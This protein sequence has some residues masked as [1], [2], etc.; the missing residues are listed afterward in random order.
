[1]KKTVLIFLTMISITL[2]A[3]EE[4]PQ[5]ESVKQKIF[6]K[7]KNSYRLNTGN[8]S[9]K[10]QQGTNSE[11]NGQYSKTYFNYKQNDD[12]SI[13]ISAHSKTFGYTTTSYKHKLTISL[14]DLAHLEALNRCYVN[15]RG[16]FESC[17][18]IAGNRVAGMYNE[19]KMQIP[20][21]FEYL[22]QLREQEAKN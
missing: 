6:R 20:L 8:F 16:N 19:I 14:R 12:D 4:P 13:T 7:K 15:C 9:L 17:A 10:P 3:I 11:P 2:L 18:A 21:F 5:P 22:E 1:M